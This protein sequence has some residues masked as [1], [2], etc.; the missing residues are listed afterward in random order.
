VGIVV[1]LIIAVVL[2]YLTINPPT[3]YRLDD[4]RLTPLAATAQR[5]WELTQ[6]PIQQ[7]ASALGLDYNEYVVTLIIEGATQTMSAML[8]ATETARAITTATPQGTH[9]ASTP[10]IGVTSAP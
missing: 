6:T 1:L 4:P 2:I 8:Q 10:S 5:R 9:A 3:D 7:T